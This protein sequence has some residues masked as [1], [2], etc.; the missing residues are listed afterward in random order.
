MWI[1]RYVLHKARV[2]LGP[3][4]RTFSVFK[5]TTTNYIGL[6]FICQ[7]GQVN[8]SKLPVLPFLAPFSGYLLNSSVFFLILKP[9][10]NYIKMTSDCGKAKTGPD[11]K[12]SLL[13]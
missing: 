12:K 9:K 3:S 6:Q 5:I 8:I 4:V 1:E 2:P 10:N 11:M 7:I 13:V